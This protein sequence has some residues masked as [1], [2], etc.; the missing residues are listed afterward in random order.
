MR[1]IIDDI[2]A[3]IAGKMLEGSGTTIL[4]SEEMTTQLVA[5]HL[6]EKF[7][8]AKTI[9]IFPGGGAEII[10]GYLP[11]GWLKQWRWTT[12]PAKRF[13]QPGTAPWAIAGRIAP[14][15]FLLGFKNMIIIDDVISSGET[16][17][18]VRRVNE[19]WIPGATWHAFTW[20][21]ERAANL[22]GFGIKY[23]VAEV[24]ERNRKVPINSLSTLIS[25]PE[26]ARNYARRN[27][28][29]P[30]QFLALLNQLKR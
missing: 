1:I 20:I 27:T 12:V 30:E 15:R 7:D 16:A 10:R 11:N 14:D 26:I 29:D 2:H 6:W 25:C 17:R 22:P 3:G 19:P 18:M 13:W 8:P 28:T 4:S 23:A 5:S 24:G 21:A 9:L